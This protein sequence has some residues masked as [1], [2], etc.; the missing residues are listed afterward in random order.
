MG[1]VFQVAY[2]VVSGLHVPQ[3]S[4]LKQFEMIILFRFQYVRGKT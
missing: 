1:C 3:T 4:P 2:I